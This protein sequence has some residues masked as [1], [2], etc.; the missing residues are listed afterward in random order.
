MGLA[1]RRTFLANLGLLAAAGG[2]AWL[3]RDRLVWPSPRP[4][5]R[6]GSTPTPW[7]DFVVPRQTL[8]II[9]VTAG[10]VPTRALIDSGAQHSVIDRALADRL[11]LVANPL[12][13][14]VA[15]GAGGGA[16]MARGSRLGIEV[17]GMEI[18]D[19]RVAVL[20]LGPMAGE[21][22]LS[23]PLIL[24]Y[25]ILRALI[26][27]IDFPGRRLRF[28]PREGYVPPPGA[29]AAPVRAAGRALRAEALVEGTAVEVLIDTGATGALALAPDAAQAAGLLAGRP[30]RA[31]SGLA[32]GGLMH[33]RMVKAG[34]VVFA[35]REFID[36]DVH[37][38][39][40]PR[41]PG[42]P[43]GLLGVDVLAAWRVILDVG[44]G[45]MW[46]ASVP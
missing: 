10:G 9:E 41:F 17:G 11:G 31:A 1:T 23:T 13:P 35:G 27:D 19:L 4:A 46:L 22:G 2:A 6:S 28:A 5:H 45:R 25:D 24:G 43:A 36:A 39:D 26:A 21:A 40:L 34:S 8:P 18:E 42:I 30:Q 3:V 37:V 20:D 15:M 16:Q 33:S 32:L 12:A 38:V 7:L 29:V 14:M 44:G